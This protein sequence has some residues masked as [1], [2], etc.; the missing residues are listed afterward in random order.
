MVWQNYGRSILVSF[1]FTF[2]IEMEVERENQ[3]THP[4]NDLN[5]T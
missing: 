5:S 1:E 3:T 2:E 4:R